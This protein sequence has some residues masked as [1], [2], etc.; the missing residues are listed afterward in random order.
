MYFYVRRGTTAA[1]LPGKHGKAPPKA[2]PKQL[3]HPQ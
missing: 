1:F 3:K 2:M